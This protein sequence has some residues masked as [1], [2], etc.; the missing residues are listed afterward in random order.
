[1][2]LLIPD[3]SE[4]QGEVNWDHLTPSYPAAIIRVH[5]GYR[6]DLY[7]ERNRERAHASG[8]RALGLYAYLVQSRS[9]E[10]QAHE[11]VH[12]LGS[13]RA[14]EWPIL[15]YEA[16][17]LTPEHATE[18]AT[19]V[20]QSLHGTKPWLY[21]S[22]YVYRIERLG[23]R[24]AIPA[25]RTWLAA[26]GPDEPSEPHELWQYTDHRTVPGI[27]GA[28]DCSAFHGDLAHLLAV[29]A[30]HSAPRPSPGP[31]AHASHPYPEGIHPGGTHP[32]ARPLQRALKRT[33][34]MDSSVVES[35]HYGPATQRAVAGFNEK[36]HLVSA[37]L[38][39][40][41]AI[42][43]RG[44]ALLMTLAYGRS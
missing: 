16:A 14:G 40:D 28:V 1:M 24:T 29:V 5:N 37:L 15:D 32:S 26:Y 27:A 43:P 4:W 44:W 8:V 7:F 36:H 2:T 11:F 9:A 17:G 20:Y 3:I 30:P 39:Y 12:L 6:A 18:W 35:D 33:G 41:P 21:A 25:T 31:T 10:E 38:A 42:G 19:V 34:W 22:E 23:A 13:L